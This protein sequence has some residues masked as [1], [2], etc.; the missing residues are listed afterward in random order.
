MLARVA[1]SDWTVDSLL[2]LIVI[3]QISCQSA[4]IWFDAR[5]RRFSNYVFEIFSK[6]YEIACGMMMVVCTEMKIKL[7]L[8]VLL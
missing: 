1:V 5:F 7:V 4:A 8:D 3:M 2:F 6:I